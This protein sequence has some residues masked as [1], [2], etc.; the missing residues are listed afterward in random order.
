MGVRGLFRLIEENAKKSI[1]TL[2]KERLAK[3]VL[4][5]DAAQLL[6]K[7]LIGSAN[8]TQENSHLRAIVTTCVHY[9]ELNATPI[10]VFDG[11]SPNI[12]HDAVMARK[13]KRDIATEFIFNLESSDDIL[14]SDQINNLAK[15]K[16]RTVTLTSGMVIECQELLSILG[17][18]WYVAN[19]EADTFAA[20]IMRDRNNRIDGIVTD[21]SD[22]LPLGAPVILRSFT[23]KSTTVQKFSLSSILEELELTHPEFIDLCVLLG[24][25][26][27]REIIGISKID[28][29][30]NYKKAI[31]IVKDNGKCDIDSIYEQYMIIL[32]ATDVTIPEDY[33][34]NFKN[35]RDY[36][37]SSIE[38]LPPIDTHWTEPNIRQFTDYMLLKK[39]DKQYCSDMSCSIW[40]Y[41][42]K[43]HR[44]DL[45]RSSYIS[46]SSYRN[47]QVRQMAMKYIATRQ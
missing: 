27:C 7:W 15:N 37:T 35:A 1:V 23:R 11:R 33:C 19:N 16:R 25:D 24:C 14:N 2:P 3:R 29:Y 46:F 32:R 47:K 43:N 5:I 45:Q 44:P 26:Y 41:W 39:F 36:Y 31:S 20:G 40:G 9:L 30:N 21:D 8:T 38:N 12:K 22:L 13:R 28:I 42:N 34:D 17:I 4:V 18:P 10:F 6:Y